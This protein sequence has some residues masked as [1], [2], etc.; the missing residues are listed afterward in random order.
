MLGFL[1]TSLRDEGGFEYKRAIVEAIFDIIHNIPEA[2]EVALAH[3]CEFIEDCEFTKLAV[4]IL[5]LLG[6]Q[7][8]QTPNPAKYL[9]YIYN[10]VILENS[11]VRAAAVTALAKIAEGVADLRP[12]II[13][14]LKRCLEDSDDEVRD[15]AAFY[16]R[17]LQEKELAQRYIADGRHFLSFLHLVYSTSD[18]CYSWATLEQQLMNYLQDPTSQSEA[19][20]LSA[21]P[22]LTKDQVEAENI[23]QKEV[24]R[25]ALVQPLQGTPTETVSQ[26]PSGDLQ[27]YYKAQIEKI[28]SLV[29]LGP[30]LKSSRVH[31]LTENDV[32]YVVNC[33]KH[34]LAKHI[35]FQ[36]ISD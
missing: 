11:P 33:I 18:S 12:R 16:L 5:Y 24:A 19:F 28:P 17:I 6:T 9:R 20:D 13:T 30:V 21:V 34:V 1:A 8:S 36:V 32:E 23:R 22:V 7:A 31:E 15:R 25:D 35:I 4:R 2:K 10:R 29:A 27:G 14:L 3:L 26:V